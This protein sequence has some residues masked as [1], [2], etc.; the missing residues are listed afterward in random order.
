MSGVMSSL[1][2]VCMVTSNSRVV[3]ENLQVLAR[4]TGAIV[5]CDVSCTIYEALTVLLD[6]DIQAKYTYVHAWL[7]DITWGNTREN[8]EVLASSSQVG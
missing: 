2:H 8:P 3:L 5:K 7:R 4:D 1:R 6:P